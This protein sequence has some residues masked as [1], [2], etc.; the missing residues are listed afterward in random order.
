MKFNLFNDDIYVE[1][2]DGSVVSYDEYQAMPPRT[3]KDL[4]VLAAPS[5]HN[6][7]Y[8]DVFADIIA[9]DIAYA[10]AV[11]GKDEVRVLVDADTRPYFEG[12]VPEDILVKASVKDIWLRDF[13]TVN[14]YDPIQFRYTAASL[15]GVQY[16]ADFIQSSFNDFVGER[17]I[18]FPTTNLLIDGGNVVD[19]YAGR[20]VTTTRF[21]EDNGFTKDEGVAA[22]KELLDATEV[23]ILPP[24]DPALAHS[25]GMVMFI[26]DNV[27]VVN[28]YDEPL[29]TEIITELTSAFPGV[30]LI[31]VPAAWDDAT[32]DGNIGSACGINVNSVV[33]TNY[34][35]VPHF[36][37]QNS[38]A[39]IAT[40]KEHTSKTVVPIP[41]ENVCQMG[42]SVRCL[43][44]QQSGEQAQ[45]LLS[46]LQ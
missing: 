15:D 4:I 27:L 5:V 25:D 8:A 45:K 3:E 34:I 14:P 26:E 11:L 12:K 16:E 21:L 18:T 1:L 32:W 2:A 42:G 31:E 36:G 28:E 6:D 9:F 44:W 24:D 29:R 35:Y 39:V 37:D 23:A 46:K 19:N 13:A 40:I 41:A 38:D 30:E 43:S 33:T 17:G 10:Q 20:A 22:L 7:Y